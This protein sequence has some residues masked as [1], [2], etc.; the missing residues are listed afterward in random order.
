M[1]E[2]RSINITEAAK[3]LRA[4]LKRRWPQVKFS[5]RS[6]KY[7]MGSHMN[8][9]W[10]DGPTQ[11]AVEEVANAYSGAR[12]DGSNDSTYYV[13]SWLLPAGLAVAATRDADGYRRGTV[14]PAPQAEAELVRFSGS[15]PDCHREIS[16]CYEAACEKAWNG[17]TEQ[18]RATL[19]RHDRFSQCDGY[20]DGYKLALFFDAA[21]VLRRP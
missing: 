17:L 3:M 2:A 5:V 18:E 14:T 15:Q 20:T 6:E 7:S 13:S 8:V 9:A 21:E 11:R 10:I 1:A 19:Q 12:F 16:A 4:E